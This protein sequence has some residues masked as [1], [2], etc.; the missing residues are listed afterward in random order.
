[1]ITLNN[2][3]HF[4][5][6][7]SISISQFSGQ[8]VGYISDSTN[9]PS[10][11]HCQ[12]VLYDRNKNSRFSALKPNADQHTKKQKVSKVFF[13]QVIQRRKV[14]GHSLDKLLIYKDIENIKTHQ[15]ETF[16]AYIYITIEALHENCIG[17]IFIKPVYA[18]NDQLDKINDMKA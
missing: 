14:Y 9:S 12:L 10:R 16:V 18:A 13:P 17:Q 4:T 2:R 6:G 1:M 7:C 11:E 15:D 3:E 8:V 5:K